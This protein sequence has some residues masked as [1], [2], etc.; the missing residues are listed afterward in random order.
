MI[1]IDVRVDCLI[2]PSARLISGTCREV[3]HLPAGAG[4]CVDFEGVKMAAQNEVE[5]CCE[6]G[7]DVRAFNLAQPI[8]WMVDEC[9]IEPS[10]E[11]LK[12]LYRLVNTATADPQLC[13]IVIVLT[14]QRAVDG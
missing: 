4:Y 12:F 2:G 3:P 5:A 6:S 13:V 7:L 8:E 14:K 9:N 1:P 11:C 10:V